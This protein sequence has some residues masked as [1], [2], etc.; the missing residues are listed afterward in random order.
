[1]KQ[2]VEPGGLIREPWPVGSSHASSA[3]A[4]TP[5]AIA[6][7]LTGHWPSAARKPKAMSGEAAAKPSLNPARP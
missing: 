2:R 1:M 5:T 3:S 6:G 4:G 7:P